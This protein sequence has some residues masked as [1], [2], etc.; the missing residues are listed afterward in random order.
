MGLLWVTVS[1]PL[2]A[3]GD[4]LLIKKGLSCECVYMFH[5][6]ARA[7]LATGSQIEAKK[8]QV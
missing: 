5:S 2:M 8:Q 1:E 7:T 4:Y 6:L 3:L